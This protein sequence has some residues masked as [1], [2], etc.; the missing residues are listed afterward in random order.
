[1]RDPFQQPRS[2]R[3]AL[4]GAAVIFGATA[5]VAPSAAQARATTAPAEPSTE[6]VSV[7]ISFKVQNVN[8]TPIPRQA[9][10]ETY[11]VRGHVWA[12]AEA[13]TDLDHDTATLYLHGLGLGEFFWTNPDVPGYDFAAQQARDGHIS[14]VVDRLGYDDSDDPP[15]KEIC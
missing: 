9:D 7:P 8:R 14:V 13:A 3:T 10:G 4:F 12:P 11:T 5:V 15:G 1:M 6:I 2:R